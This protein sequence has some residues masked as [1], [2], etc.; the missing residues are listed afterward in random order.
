ME[1]Y[2][3]IVRCG[4][5]M[6][7]QYYA[8]C[9]KKSTSLTYIRPLQLQNKKSVDNCPFFRDKTEKQKFPWKSA[10]RITKYWPT[11]LYWI[12]SVESLN[13]LAF[14]EQNL[15]SELKHK[16]ESLIR[17]QSKISLISSQDNA[18]LEP[19][20]L[21]KPCRSFTSLALKIRMSPPF[22]AMVLRCPWR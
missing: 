14:K 19:S 11:L 20:N 21:L 4:A 22:S 10:I 13:I 2:S 8:Y 1:L 16:N 15:I 7:L 5:V 6:T 17:R 18:L 9:I 12:L 3:Y